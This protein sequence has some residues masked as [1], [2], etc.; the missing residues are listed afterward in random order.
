MVVNLTEP[1]KV[2]KKIKEALGGEAFRLN[3]SW[4]IRLWVNDDQIANFGDFFD[5]HVITDVTSPMD[6]NSAI[7]VVHLGSQNF[8]YV[9]GDIEPDEWADVKAS[10]CVK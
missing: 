4:Y 8:C 6:Y 5:E 9:N 2:K 7:A 3:S 1:T 10:L